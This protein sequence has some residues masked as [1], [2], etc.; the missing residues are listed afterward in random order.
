MTDLVEAARYEH[1]VQADLA[2]LYLGSEGIE[3]V[4][5]DTGHASMWGSVGGLFMP[6]RLMVLDEDLTAARELLRDYSG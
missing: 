1:R 2:Q 4:L 5:F 3:A 6:I